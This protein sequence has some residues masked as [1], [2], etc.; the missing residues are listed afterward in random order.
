[1]KKLVCFTSFFVFKDIAGGFI[2][3]VV[4]V[5]ILLKYIYCIRF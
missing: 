4:V 2:S 5:S 1:L 3:L